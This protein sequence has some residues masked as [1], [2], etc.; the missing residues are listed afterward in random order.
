MT[1]EQFKETFGASPTVATTMRR[2]DAFANRAK[3]TANLA[4]LDALRSALEKTL[5]T[6]R[7]REAALNA[8]A[9]ERPLADYEQSAFLAYR[10][11]R[12]ALEGSGLTARAGLGPDVAFLT[13]FL[14]KPGL[15]ETARRI[16]ANERL[17]AEAEA[18]LARWPTETTTHPF[19]YT[20]PPRCAYRPDG[21]Y[22][23]PGEVVLLNENAAYAMRDR[24]EPVVPT[25]DQ[26]P[27]VVG[28]Q[29]GS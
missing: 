3:A 13:P 8:L 17:L 20:G 22:V 14:G 11:A 15:A 21:G 12:V 7:D 24:F 4:A 27:L 16:E 1:L 29:T 6:V 23:Q 26:P 2:E 18:V 19:R 28:E 10:D 5:A 9:N 25:A